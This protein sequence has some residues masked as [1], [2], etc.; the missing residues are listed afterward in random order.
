MRELSSELWGEGCSRDAQFAFTP[1]I[2]L[3]HSLTLPVPKS[4]RP[5]GNPEGWR[6]RG[7]WEKKQRVLV[8]RVGYLAKVATILEGDMTKKKVIGE[9]MTS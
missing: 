1:A 5:Q 7:T 6:D 8:M 2:S 9:M 3:S 4:L